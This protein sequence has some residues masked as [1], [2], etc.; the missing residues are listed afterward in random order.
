MKKYFSQFGTV[1]RLRLSRNKKTGASKH[2]AFIE[3]A[4]ADVADIVAKT[5]HNYLMFG[6]ILQC[7]TIPAEQVHADLFKGA[8][9][10]F[11][12][13]P[14]NKKAGSAMAR[15]AER[16]VWEK[17]VET[18]KHRRASKAKALKEEFGYEFSPPAVKPVDGVSRSTSAI[19]DGVAQQLVIEDKTRAKGHTEAE[20]ETAG[21][22][23][24]TAPAQ[25]SKGKKNKKRKS[26]VTAESKEEPDIV[27]NA[28][29]PK[30]KKAKKE[31]K[32][33]EDSPV[34]E[35]KRKAKSGD[36]EGAKPKKTKKAKA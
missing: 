23:D 5:M 22:E 20:A 15:G 14:R 30:A 4:N 25:S 35:K 26:D 11:K 13:D 2:Y 28:T 18:E 24:E 32:A 12:V 33:L 16:A 17:R 6:H 9:Q 29:P 27:A 8:N 34:T 21:A 3:F 31:T 10:R 19:E 36:Q 7:R 1:T